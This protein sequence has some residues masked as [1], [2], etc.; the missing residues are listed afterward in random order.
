[1]LVDVL[2]EVGLVEGIVGVEV[3]SAADAEASLGLDYLL[4]V[5]FLGE[6]AFFQDDSLEERFDEDGFSC[7]LL[8]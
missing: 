7:V 4:E 5:D 1:M 2:V 3:P 8:R 6:V